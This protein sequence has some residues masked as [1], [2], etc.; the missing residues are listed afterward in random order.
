MNTNNTNE[1]PVA[2]LDSA[3]ETADASP[4]AQ[5]AKAKYRE[6]LASL[7][8]A[9][10]AGNLARE[11]N[12]VAVAALQLDWTK[13]H[14]G[15]WS[16]LTGG[17]AVV[18]N[19]LVDAVANAA[20]TAVDVTLQLMQGRLY[21]AGVLAVAGTLA[22]ASMVGLAAYDL[23]RILLG[24]T[25]SEM[26]FQ[27][28]AAGG[29]RWLRSMWVAHIDGGV[30]FVTAKEAAAA[31]VA[32]ADMAT[33]VQGTKWSLWTTIDALAR[34]Y[35]TM[36]HKGGDAPEVRVL[37]ENYRVAKLELERLKLLESEIADAAPI[38]WAPPPCT[39]TA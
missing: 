20:R 24:M 37:F 9:M 6:A 1:T 16:N 2:A 13:T 7:A 33:L 17:A 32:R 23:G 28:K 31:V 25:P 5:T 4:E 11:A 30:N 19:G 10:T 29:V 8:S 35:A 27:V 21:T 18:G 14:P 36:A 12:G 22:S 15:Y 3:V 39:A 38:P 26:T 34:Q